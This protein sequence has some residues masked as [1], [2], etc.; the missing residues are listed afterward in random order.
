MDGWIHFRMRAAFLE[1]FTN[2]MYFFFHF[3]QKFPS[4]FGGCVKIPR[5]NPGT[6]E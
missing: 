6:D 4:G 5:P 1:Q 2:N 3:V